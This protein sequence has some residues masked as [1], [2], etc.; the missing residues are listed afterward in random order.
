MAL[1]L[2]SRRDLG[3]TAQHL[4]ETAH[5]HVASARPGWPSAAWPS[6]ARAIRRRLLQLG[7]HGAERDGADPGV[8][9]G[10]G[11]LLPACGG[12]RAWRE[13]GV[14]TNEGRERGVQTNEGSLSRNP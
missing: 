11:V 2:G 9:C 8:L 4:E 12:G 3:L 10:D 5:L 13:R 1:G 14:Q 7:P 6:A